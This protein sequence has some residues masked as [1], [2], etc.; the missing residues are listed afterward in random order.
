MES[1]EFMTHTELTQFVNDNNAEVV[2]IV[3]KAQIFILFYT[4]A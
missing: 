4:P 1:R 3:I 2:A